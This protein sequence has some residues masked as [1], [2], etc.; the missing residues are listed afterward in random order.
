M[1]N[2]AIQLTV[3]VCERVTDRTHPEH[4]P[5]MP[6]IKINQRSQTEHA[7]PIQTIMFNLTKRFNLTLLDRKH[8]LRTQTL[9]DA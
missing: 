9:Y 7:T 2:I 1:C 3:F 4:F 5:Y 6:L 8:F